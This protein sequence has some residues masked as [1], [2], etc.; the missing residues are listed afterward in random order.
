MRSHRHSWR[1]LVDALPHVPAQDLQPGDLIAHRGRPGVD[2]A[3]GR[4][5]IRVEP[6]EAEGRVRILQPFLNPRYAGEESP[7]NAGAEQ[8]IAVLPPYW[9]VGE[10]REL[11]E[12]DITAARRHV[13]ARAIETHRP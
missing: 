2:E 1:T 8:P 7:L 5:V 6:A 12:A 9:P 11:T 4:P 13:G 10:T 3:G